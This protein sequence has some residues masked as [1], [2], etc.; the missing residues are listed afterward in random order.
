MRTA[1]AFQDERKRDR[2]FR[3]IQ[4]PEIFQ[5][6]LPGNNEI[7]PERIHGTAV[8]FIV[9]SYA[10]AFWVIRVRRQQCGPEAMADT[11]ELPTSNERQKVEKLR[12][13]NTV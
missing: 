1:K 8:K 11:V 10:E 7:H 5:Q 3:R 12:S 13:E 2:V 6:G 4:R 9:A